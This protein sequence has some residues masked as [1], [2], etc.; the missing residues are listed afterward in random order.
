MQKFYTE[1]KYYLHQLVTSTFKINCPSCT[2]KFLVLKNH[3]SNFCASS[4]LDFLP[5]FSVIF[6]KFIIMSFGKK[7]YIKFQYHTCPSWLSWNW[8]WYFSRIFTKFNFQV[9]SLL[10]ILPFCP[11][12]LFRPLWRFHRIFR[13]LVHL[14]LRL[15]LLRIPGYFLEL[16]PSSISSFYFETMSLLASRSIPTFVQA[17]RGSTCLS[18]FALRMFSLKHGAADLWKPCATCDIFVRSVSAK[19]A[20]RGSTPAVGLK[21]QDLDL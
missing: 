3:P 4:Y 13:F 17:L 6:D 21:L 16:I 11:W 1:R 19:S 15:Y 20:L 5:W 9:L 18:T 7:H 14:S 10:F 2:C 8:N 12:S